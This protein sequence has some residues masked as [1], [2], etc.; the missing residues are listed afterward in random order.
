[1]RCLLDKGWNSRSKPCPT[2]TEAL[3]FFLCIDQPLSLLSCTHKRKPS[4]YESLQ[5]PPCGTGRCHPFI[6]QLVYLSVSKG[7]RR[8][9][10]KVKQFDSQHMPNYHLT[11]AF[12]QFSLQTA[13]GNSTEVTKQ[14][15]SSA[16]RFSSLT[17]TV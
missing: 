10:K 2:P 16:E 1:M 8:Q 4:L 14:R 6:C 13:V 15:Q 9:S 5:P 7:N 3:R 17:Q 12:Y 11:K